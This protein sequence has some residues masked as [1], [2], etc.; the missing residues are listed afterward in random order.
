MALLGPTVAMAALVGTVDNFNQPRD[1]QFGTLPA[2]SAFSV[3]QTDVA[4]GPFNAMRGIF[5]ANF[6]PSGSVASYNID[7]GMVAFDIAFGMPGDSVFSSVRYSGVSEVVGFPNVGEP[8]IN[9][10]TLPSNGDLMINFSI[11]DGLGNFA[12]GALHKAASDLLL[13]SGAP[14]NNTGADYSDVVSLFFDFEYAVR[15]GESM[16]GGGVRAIEVIPGNGSGWGT[17]G[18]GD[19]NDPVNWNPGSAPDANDHTAILGA[20]ITAPRTVTTDTDATVKAIQFSNDNQYA[21]AG[22]GSLNLDADSGN[23]HIV[24]TEGSHQFQTQVNLHDNTDASVA[25]G[26]ALSF[27][28][29]LTLNGNTL[30]KEGLGEIAIRNNLVSGGGTVNSGNQFPDSAQS[31]SLANSTGSAI[32]VMAGTLAGNGSVGGD[33]I[34]NGGTASPSSVDSMF[35]ILFVEGDFEQIDPGILELEVAGLTPGMEY[36]Q[37]NVTGAVKLGGTL[38]ITLLGDPSQAQ[39]GA[40][41]DIIVSDQIMG[42]FDA[43]E[44]PLGPGGAPLLNLITLGGGTLQLQVIPLPA[45]FPLFLVAVISVGVAARNRTTRKRPSY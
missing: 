1:P 7:N 43:F 2:G 23:A 25:D 19:W 39:I 12:D 35:G 3:T 45:V 42:G 16:A 22:T 10:W 40:T 30:T 5:V 9:V 11:H 37:L 28:N 20:A 31:P 15:P 8:T 33:L 17:D 38:S 41:L 36:D 24:V 32:I 34:N 27:N 14:T 44:L 13:S 4:V 29:Q 18:T 6:G 26:A 21:V